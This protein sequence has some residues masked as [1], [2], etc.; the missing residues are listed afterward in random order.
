MIRFTSA[1]GFFLLSLLPVVGQAVIGEQTYLLAMENP[2]LPI[3]RSFLAKE[4]MSGA[5][6]KLSLRLGEHE[7]GGTM[8]LAEIK[9]RIISFPEK[10]KVRFSFTEVRTKT[11]IKIDEMPGEISDV[12]KPLSGKDVLVEKKDGEWVARIEKGGVLEENE[13]EIRKELESL[14]SFF[15]EDEDAKLYG[16]EARKIGDKWDVDPRFL[17]GMGEFEVNGGKLSLHLK[18]VKEYEGDE[19]AVIE[20]IFQL[21]G[22]STDP[23]QKGLD[24]TFSGSS[25]VVRSLTLLTDLK[26]TM[27][28]RFK[29][30][31]K[32]NPD[33]AGSPMMTV[34]G[35]MK[36][37]TRISPIPEKE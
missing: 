15:N 6:A 7:V 12:V 3:G 9:D 17:P 33:E 34:S 16:T 14:E 24:A 8:N 26:R 35:D 36:M 20:M 29:L 19:C 21:K 31:G 18:E 5:D 37:E 25:R 27:D 1:L 2:E 4:R 22:F 13:E 32:T 23:E 11:E 30:A 10:G 28:T